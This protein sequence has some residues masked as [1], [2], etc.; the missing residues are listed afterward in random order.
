MHSLPCP[1]ALIISRSLVPTYLSR[2]SGIPIPE[3]MV[4]KVDDKCS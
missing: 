3:G 1:V 4:K 2:P